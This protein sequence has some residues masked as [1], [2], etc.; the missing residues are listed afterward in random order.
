MK[1]KPKFRLP[2]AFW[3]QYPSELF[4]NLK[5]SASKD[6][7]SWRRGLFC[8]CRSRWFVGLR[9]HLLPFLIKGVAKTDGYAGKSAAGEYDM[10]AKMTRLFSAMLTAGFRFPKGYK[11]INQRG[12]P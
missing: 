10:K 8:C 1:V 7:H 5:N 3:L 12:E 4:K 2:G 11:M 9:F 6:G